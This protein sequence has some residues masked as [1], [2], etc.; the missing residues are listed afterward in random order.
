MLIEGFLRSVVSGFCQGFEEPSGNPHV[1]FQVG[2]VVLGKGF[3]ELLRTP[4]QKDGGGDVRTG[5]LFRPFLRVADAPFRE[6]GTGI[7]AAREAGILTVEMEAAALY[8]FAT[9]RSKPVL[10]FAHVTNR[11]AVEEGDFEKG[12]AGGSLDALAVIAATARR[13]RAGARR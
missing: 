7:E 5:F 13:W 11:M 3:R 9:A 4:D 10:C 12:E 8:A 1:G 6:T 2:G